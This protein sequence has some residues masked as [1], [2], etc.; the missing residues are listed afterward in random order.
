LYRI[1]RNLV[2]DNHRQNQNRDPVP[3]ENA[4]EDLVESETPENITELTLTFKRVKKT[5]GDLT[6]DQRE[7][8]ELRFL[9]GLSLKEVALT[10]DKSVS[11]VK[12]LQ[13][14]GL[15]SLR[16]RLESSESA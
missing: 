9:A 1:A 12:G 11:A 4:A 14:R 5:L 10:M 7:V 8:V 2:I 13:H 15:S 16:D 6:P 3:F